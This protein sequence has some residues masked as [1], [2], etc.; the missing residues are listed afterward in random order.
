MAR[1][2]LVCGPSGAGKTTYSISQAREISA[3]RFS[4]DP[5][6]Q[7]L[8]SQDMKSLDYSWIVDR[9]HR[10]Y[11]QIWEVASQILQ[12]NGNVI[13]DLGFAKKTDRE[14][15]TRRAHSIGITAELHY[16]DL[17]Q[18]IR[19]ARV[20][21]RNIN[22]DPDLYCFDVTDMMFDFMESGIE[23]PEPEELENGITVNTDPE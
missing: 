23:A 19:R 21:Q 12:L 11:E 20:E 1:L 7:T 22:K 3:V 10:C 2:L 15:F 5:W 6:M 18:E 14:L 4:I 9:V 16:L 8:F 17:P 13:L